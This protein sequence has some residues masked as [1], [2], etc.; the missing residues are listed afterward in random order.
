[1][2][3]KNA[4][5][6]KPSEEPVIEEPK[7]QK[8]GVVA[9]VLPLLACVVLMVGSAWAFTKFFLLEQIT[10]KLEA[11]G[12]VLEDPSEEETEKTKPKA[13][14]K[15]LESKAED[16]DVLINLLVAGMEEKDLPDKQLKAWKEKKKKK[17]DAFA[18]KVFNQPIKVAEVN[19]Y[20]IAKFV[21]DSSQSRAHRE[22]LNQI[23]ND[24]KSFI[25]DQAIRLIAGLSSFKDMEEVYAK[26][27]TVKTQLYNIIKGY[28]SEYLS[29]KNLILNEDLTFSVLAEEWTVQ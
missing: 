20:L 1:M 3:K 9:T 10:A 28:V 5:E 12:L 15:P 7:P 19:R 23:L 8:K 2:V 16:R 4:P 27:S 11:A 13:E 24:K 17:F 29:E 25:N 14:N 26:N 18:T 21:I 6:K 22:M